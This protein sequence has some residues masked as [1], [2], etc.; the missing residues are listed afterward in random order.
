MNGLTSRVG[1]FLNARCAITVPDGHPM[2]VDIT[3]LNTAAPNPHL[4]ATIRPQTRL[5]CPTL[6]V[7]LVTMLAMEKWESWSGKEEEQWE[8]T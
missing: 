6:T 5:T 1:K 2:F 3:V 4:K 8:E 7:L